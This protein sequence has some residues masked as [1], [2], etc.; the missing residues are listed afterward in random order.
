MRG[1]FVS[2]VNPSAYFAR[3]VKYKTEMEYE[4]LDA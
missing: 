2:I 4:I 1:F 3:F